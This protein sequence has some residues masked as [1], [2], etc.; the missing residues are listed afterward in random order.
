[1]TN[2][3]SVGSHELFEALVGRNETTILVAQRE[4]CL[5]VL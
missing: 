4:A 2:T 5:P 3:Q 1:M